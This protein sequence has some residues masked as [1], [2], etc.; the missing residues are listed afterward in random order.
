MLLIMLCFCAAH[1]RSL[2]LRRVTASRSQALIE[3]FSES[4][5]PRY[6]VAD[7]KLYT[8]ENSQNLGKLPFITRIP[9]TLTVMQQVITQALD[10]DQWAPMDETY[11]FQRFDL[12]HYGI[13]QR[14]LVIYSEA[15]FRRAERKACR[16]NVGIAPRKT[17]EKARNKEYQKVQKQLF[18]PSLMP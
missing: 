11:R 10:F 7:S 15:A 12:C 13:A 16:R 2:R 14:W 9:N 3:T 17:L 8:E 18:H 1:R 5:T 4:T 6:L